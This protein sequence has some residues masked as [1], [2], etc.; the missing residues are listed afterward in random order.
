M[1]TQSIILRTKRTFN[2]MLRS[3]DSNYIT[4]TSSD[5]LSGSPRSRRYSIPSCEAQVGAPLSLISKNKSSQ[6]KS[7]LVAK[8]PTYVNADIQ[9]AD[10]LNDNNGKSGIYK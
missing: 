6:N 1:Q 10:I 2:S 5:K 7:T 4:P 3:L 8:G 9:K